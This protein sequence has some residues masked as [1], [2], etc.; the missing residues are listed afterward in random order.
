MTVI[1]LGRFGSSV[2]RTLHELGYEV[3]AIDLSDKNIQTASEYV[4]LA[5]QGDGTDQ[6]LLEQLNVDKSDVTVVAQG[7]NLEASVL[8]TLLMKKLKVPWVV[9]KAKTSLHGELLRK[10]GADRVVFPELDAGVRLAHSLGVRHISDY[11]SLSAN[12]GVAKV[13]APANLIGHT[14]EALTQGQQAKLNVLL[15]KRRGQLITVPHYQEV[16]QP[17]DELLIVGAD[18]D[19]ETFVERDPGKMS[20]RRADR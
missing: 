19:I 14:I 7:E 11:I 17:H 2:A 3:T 20:A 18:P 1:G 12:A 15:I 6:E 8:S 10:V 13:E 4:T 9:A 16:I 5:A